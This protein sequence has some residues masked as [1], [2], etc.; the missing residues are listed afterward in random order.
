MKIN[1]LSEQYY[2]L[3]YKDI[4]R[5]PLINRYYR[6]FL[7]KSYCVHTANYNKTRLNN[8]SAY[9]YVKLEHVYTFLE[10]LKLSSNEFLL[11]SVHQ[12]TI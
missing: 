12:V 9:E 5:K 1:V 7:K 2:T 6:L 3:K 8:V 11:W 10:K 4:W